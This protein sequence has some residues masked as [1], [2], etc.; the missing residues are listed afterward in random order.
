MLSKGAGDWRESSY[1]DYPSIV[2]ENEFIRIEIVPGR[3]SKVV[4]LQ[5]AETGR[6]WLFGNDR[7]WEPLSYGMNWEDGDR[8]GWDEMFPT[9]LPCAGADPGWRQASFPDHGE[10]W[11][12]PWESRV[13]PEEAQMWVEGVQVP[14]RLSKTYR[15]SGRTVELLYRLENPTPHRFTYMWAPHALLAIREGMMLAAEPHQVKIEV[16]FTFGNRLQLEKGFSPYPQAVT[17]D[18]A[19][20]DLSELFADGAVHAEKYWFTQ[21]FHEGLVTIAD[22][23]TGESLQYIVNPDEV[24]Y[25]AVWVNNGAL[26]GDYNAAIEPATAYMDS[27]EFATALGKAKAVEGFS[28]VTWSFKIR[29]TSRDER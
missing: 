13:S 1:R 6:E 19:K 29:L 7:E 25:L 12:L 26:W 14:Y 10:V 16:P 24:P 5:N 4:S 18:G 11:A 23:Q 28:S 27:V 22:S 17:T 9:I 21:T 8:S 2:G 20:T 15:L 3:G